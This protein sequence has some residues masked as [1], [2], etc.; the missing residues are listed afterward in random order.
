M[1]QYVI[2]ASAVVEWLLDTEAGR[3]VQELVKGAELTAPVLLDAEV[4][5]ALRQGVQRGDF[6][7]PRAERAIDDLIVWPINLVPHR[8]LLRLAWRYRNNVS[9]YD[10]LYVA[11]AA[12]RRVPLLT[13]DGRLA[14]AEGLDIAVQHV[15]PS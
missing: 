8:D 6:D 1:T 5:S 3:A 7:G 4:L 15:G 2:D 9:A 10:A 11:L 14:R 13:A 12:S